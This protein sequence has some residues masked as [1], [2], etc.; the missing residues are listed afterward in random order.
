V[1]DIIQVAI[2]CISGLKT[3]H[4]V[5]HAN[6]LCRLALDASNGQEGQAQLHHE[7]QESCNYR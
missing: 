2:D 6:G 4:D 1:L 7:N 3:H 5:L